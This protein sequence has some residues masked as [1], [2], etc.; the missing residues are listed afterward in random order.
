MN[1]ILDGK[2]IGMTCYCLPYVDTVSDMVF[3]A[4]AIAA[5][6]SDYLVAGGLGEARNE[7][8]GFG[9]DAHNPKRPG[10]RSRGWS[11]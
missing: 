3:W 6:E 4:D 5:Q 1:G 7:G 11:V 9:L 10:V 8:N 2:G